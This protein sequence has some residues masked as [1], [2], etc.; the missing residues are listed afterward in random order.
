MHSPEFVQITP[1]PVERYR[2]LLGDGLDEI[3]LVAADARRKFAGRAIW[4]VSST[5]RGGGVAEMLHSMLPYVR[6]VGVDTRWVVLREGPDF[7]TVTKRLHNHLHG[8]PGDGGSLGAEERGVYERVLAADADALGHL[9][10][11]GDVA[12]LHDPQ[13]AGLVGPLQKSGVK[14]IWRCHIGVDETNELARQAQLFLRPYVESADAFVFSRRKYAWD[15]LD[16]GRV[17][18][19]P[20]AIDPFSPK[21]QELDASMVEGIL[22]RLGLTADAPQVSPTF[23]KADGT[24][25]RVERAAEVLQDEPLPDGAKLVAQVSRWDRLKD[26]RGLL[27]CF[28]RYITGEDIHLVLAAPGN[29]SG[30]GRPGGSG[31]VRR[32]RRVVAADA[33]GAAPAR[34]PAQPPDGRPG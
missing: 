32:R 25:G 7:F 13:T 11:E 33:A 31:R 6:G 26:P 24:P 34:A 29:P 15:G 23:L 10:Q 22:G 2:P 28:E 30:R 9:V 1:Q 8:D 21:N 16:H 4:H 5:A 3:E 19:M 27:E 17:W 12:Y 20:P 18:L 14:V